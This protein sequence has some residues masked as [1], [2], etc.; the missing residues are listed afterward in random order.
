MI[1]IPHQ[2]ANISTKLKSHNAKA[3]LVGGLIR[4]YFLDQESKDYDIE[5]YGIQD[6][7]ELQNILSG[8]GSVNLVG[9]SFGVLKLTLDGDEYD[10]SLPRTE[11]KCGDK[12]NEF[13]VSCDANLSYTDAFSRRDFTIN[14][15]GYDI[16]TGD[17]IDPF[18]GI[19]DLEN[20]ILKHIN[21]DTFIEDPLRVYR[22]VQFVSRFNLQIDTYTY[23]LCKKMVNDEMLEFLPKERVYIELQKLLLKSPAPSIGFEL[24]RSLEILRYFP[25]LEAI[26]DVPQS[27]K[28]HPEGDVWI[29][30]MMCLDEMARLISD[31]ESDDKKLNE[32][33]MWATLCHDFGKATTTQVV[34]D[35]ITAMGH[36]EAG[37]EPMRSFMYRVTNE[38]SLIGGIEPLIRH[39]LAPSQFYQGGAKA[40]AIRRLSTKVNIAELVTLARADFL[41]RTTPE[42]LSRIYK[43]GDW[44]L[45]CAKELGV[46]DNAPA[47]L[48]QGRDLIILGLAPSPKFKKLLHTTYEAQLDGQINNHSEALEFARKLI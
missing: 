10:F 45:E 41:G 11:N 27:H 8:F 26:I 16:E 25:E 2:L 43:A 5:V 38:H 42:S 32:K 35:K 17:F 33:L 40:P 18:C 30:T 6:I 39:H 14:A 28:W 15:I 44:L 34:G 37:I 22:A 46:H 36:E 1:Q 13:I 12:H 4:D 21:D 29:H 31:D 9:K 3:I 23:E 47:A 20:S 24:M 19:N 48:L 7:E